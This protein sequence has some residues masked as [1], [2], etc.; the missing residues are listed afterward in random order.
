MDTWHHAKSLA[1]Q[2]MR[3][4][5]SDAKQL[6]FVKEGVRVFERQ[7]MRRHCVMIHGHGRN[8]KCK[9]WWFD[10]TGGRVSSYVYEEARVEE[11][12]ARECRKLA[13]EA[14]D[15]EREARDAVASA[16]SEALRRLRR[17]ETRFYKLEDAYDKHVHDLDKE[18]DSL[19]SLYGVKWVAGFWKGKGPH[20][21]GPSV[22]ASVIAEGLKEWQ[23]KQVV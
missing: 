20:T 3:E 22:R 9:S 6:R 19:K 17:V 2:L 5:R 1:R 10:L 23:Q 11:A 7:E 14:R 21:V 8:C 13:L 15:F 12:K 18:N 4:A 16:S